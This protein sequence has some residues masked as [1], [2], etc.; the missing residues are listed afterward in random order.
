MKQ[1]PTEEPKSSA[2]FSFPIRLDSHARL[3]GGTRARK[4][5][6]TMMLLLLLPLLPLRFSAT[7]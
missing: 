7:P 6:P 5:K 4:L 1:N 2:V 3:D